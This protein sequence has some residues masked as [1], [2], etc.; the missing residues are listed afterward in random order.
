[1]SNTEAFD[2]SRTKAF[3]GEEPHF[4]YRF[5]KESCCSGDEEFLAERTAGGAI[6]GEAVGKFPMKYPS[7]ECTAS[8]S[9]AGVAGGS[10]HTG[11]GAIPLLP[12]IRCTSPL[13]IIELSQPPDAAGARGTIASGARRFV[14]HPLRKCSKLLCHVRFLRTRR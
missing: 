11:G 9:N 3:A 10:P 4:P 7:G 5:S 13:R 8:G 1:M 14:S 12:A 2:R 6:G